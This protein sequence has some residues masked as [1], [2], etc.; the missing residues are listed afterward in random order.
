MASGT[1]HSSSETNGAFL[2]IADVP[3]ARHAAQRWPAT[4]R[5]DETELAS[6]RLRRRCTTGVQH[7][8]HHR[9]P[10][11][12]Y[13]GAVHR[14]RFARSSGETPMSADQLPRS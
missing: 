12:A 10:T 4:S 1:S 9:A 5:R 2:S 6:W 14:S 13:D 3:S 11:G 8:E 7:D